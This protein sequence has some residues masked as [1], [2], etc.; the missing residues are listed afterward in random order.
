MAKIKIVHCLGALNTGGAETLVMNVY[1]KINREQFTFDFLLFNPNSGFYDEEASNL[2]AHLYYCP[3]LSKGIIPYIKSLIAF[4]K[5]E[6]IDVV[7]SHMDWQGGFIAYAAHQAGIKKIVVH[8]HANQKMFDVNP[9]YH[10]LIELN[11]YLIAKYATSCVACS[12]EAGDSLFKKE[13]EIVTNGIDFDKFRN[14]D[15]KVVNQLRKE[16]RIREDEQVLGH[17]GS[18]SENKN[19]RFLIKVFE[20]LYARNQH[21]KL[22]LVGD[23]NTRSI[24]EKEV[25]EQGL[26]NQII[27][28]GIRGE[29]PEIMSLFDIFLFPSRLEGLGIVAIEAQ[30]SGLPCIVSDS[31]PKEIDIGEHLIHWSSLDEE[32][33]L[34]ILLNE[35]IEKERSKIN[36]QNLTFQY[37]IEYTVQKLSQMYGDNG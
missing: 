34:E 13:Y 10:I 6:T 24:L 17:V 15:M 7:H 8:S 21:Y 29:I 18:F 30:A 25:K 2:G 26:E 12:K 9:A 5:S 33:W 20:K 11:K 14:P 1:R 35:N 31:V 22:I 23:G 27:F 28:A 16:F 3:P 4:F 36:N 19:Q 32:E 37:S